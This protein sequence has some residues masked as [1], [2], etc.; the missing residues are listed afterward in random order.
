M[1]KQANNYSVAVKQTERF[2]G[3]TVPS[4]I[5]E[6]EANLYHVLFVKSRANSQT[7][8]FENK[9]RIQKFHKE[10]FEKIADKGGFNRLGYDNVFVFHNP[11]IVE[12]VKKKTTKKEVVEEDFQNEVK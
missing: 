8:R 7:L 5:E 12:E 11:T 9:A 2:E 3:I 4:E 6:N 1:K 10:A